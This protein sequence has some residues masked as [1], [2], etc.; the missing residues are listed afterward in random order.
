[1][2][3]EKILPHKLSMNYALEPDPVEAAHDGRCPGCGSTHIQFEK[4]IGI[5]A[6]SGI[7]EG[8]PFQRVKKTLWQCCT[9]MR[10]FT[11]NKFYT[12]NV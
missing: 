11:S 5:Y 12:G 3:G 7:W 9:C 4:D 1:M 2:M 6:V 10:L 8:K